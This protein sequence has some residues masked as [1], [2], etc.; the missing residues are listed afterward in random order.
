MS[1][2]FARERLRHDL[3][4]RRLR[5]LRT[6]RPAPGFVRVTLGGEDLAGFAAP[7]PADHVKM[8]FPAPDGETAS[9][10]YTPYAFRADAEGGPE[11]DVDFVLHGEGGAGGGPGGGPAA[12][13]A[14][15]AAP[16]DEIAIGG[17]RGS[18]L[19]PRD[20]ERA[21]LVADESALP[22]A[23]RWLDAFG[24]LGDVPVTG[25]FAVADEATSA[26]LADREGP[27]RDLR[28]F[29]GQD[30]DARLADALHGLDIDEGTFLFLAGEATALIPLRRHLRRE[31]GLPKAQAEVNGYWKRG[32]VA[33]DHHAPL[34][35]ADPED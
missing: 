27:R 2:R 33:L 4:R 35:P 28:W 9:R 8:F 7:G 23:A 29:A 15:N 5:V 19:P 11:L 25:L 13:W 26:Y 16:G 21:V 18:A 30:R 1:E 34:D 32:T 10:D 17:P 12:D 3:V 22:A 24:A 14:A 6:S 31:L 20:V